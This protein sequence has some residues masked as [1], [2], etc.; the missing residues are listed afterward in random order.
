VTKLFED[1]DFAPGDDVA[2]SPDEEWILMA[3]KPLRVSEIM[4]MENFR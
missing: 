4:L 3:R 2:V 1:G